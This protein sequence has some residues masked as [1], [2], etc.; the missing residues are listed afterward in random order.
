MIDISASQFERFVSISD[1]AFCVRL[2]SWLTSN[3]PGAADL[4][5][6]AL[7]VLIDRQIPLARTFGAV[8]E[9]DIVKWCML[10]ILTS[11]Q[12]ISVPAVAAYLTDTPGRVGR[13]LDSILRTIGALLDSSDLNRTPGAA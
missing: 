6:V 8:S 11:E 1:E 10:A 12:F 2:I 7:R 4:G 5:A 3:A 13:K 9:R